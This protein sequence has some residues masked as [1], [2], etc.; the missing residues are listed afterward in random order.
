MY[1]SQRTML[2]LPGS[3]SFPSEGTSDI[4][5][6]ARHHKPVTAADA[7][8]RRSAWAASTHAQ[9]PTS[10]TRLTSSTY[11]SNSRPDANSAQKLS[12]RSPRRSSCPG[13]RPLAASSSARSLWISG[14]DR[15]ITLWT[16]LRENSRGP[17]GTRF[18]GSMYP[19]ATLAVS[20]STCLF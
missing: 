18:R 13:L 5:T 20:I 10:R 11:T 19:P 8:G 2:L 1:D 16:V 15:S 4:P 12:S 9:F 7:L 14:D 17:P 6:V 3:P